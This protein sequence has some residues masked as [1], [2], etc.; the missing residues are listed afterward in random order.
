V[1]APEGQNI[2][3]RESLD[4]TALNIQSTKQMAEA[5]KQSLKQSY[6]SSKSL[7]QIQELV[8][9]LKQLNKSVVE[10]RELVQQY[11]YLQEQS[12]QK[13]AEL[14]DPNSNSSNM[15]KMQLYEQIQALAVQMQ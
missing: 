15:N 6:Q 4:Q 9:I 10:R 7:K 11:V 5:R 13:Q 3:S 14:N 2:C 12:D 8:T 1:A